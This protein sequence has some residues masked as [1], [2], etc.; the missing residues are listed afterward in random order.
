MDKHEQPNVPVYVVDLSGLQFQRSYNS[1]RLVLIT[2]GRIDDSPATGLEDLIFVN[3]V[4]EKK[5]LYQEASTRAGQGDE[6]FIKVQ[7]KFF[8]FK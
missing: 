5:V 6:R 7:S 2:S 1:G 8:F 3:V 4:G